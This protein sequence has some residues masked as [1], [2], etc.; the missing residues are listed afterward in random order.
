MNLI[1]LASGIVPNRQAQAL[2]PIYNSIE[3]FIIECRY[4]S[5]LSILDIG[6]RMSDIRYLMLSNVNRNKI[7]PIGPYMKPSQGF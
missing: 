3:L 5:H 2:S 1:P 4:R 6:V 7:S